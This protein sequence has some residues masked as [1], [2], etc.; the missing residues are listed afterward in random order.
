M[1][2]QAEIRGQ[3]KLRFGFVRNT[4]GE[5]RK[6]AWPSREEA[7][8]LTLIVLIVTI[9]IA[10]ILGVLDFAFSEFVDAVLIK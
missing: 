5:L 1:K 10:I 4:V 6:V 8:R 7:T 2:R 3:Q 9:A